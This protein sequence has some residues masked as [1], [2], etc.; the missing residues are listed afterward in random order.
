MV[1]RLLV[2]LTVVA[3]LARPTTA[4]AEGFLIIAN[5]SVNVS[6]PLSVDELAAIY[7]L[8]ITAWPDGTQI[9]PVNR[10]ATS[11]IRTDFTARVLREDSATL[12]AYWNEMHFMGKQ[13]PVVQESQ[14]SVI[15]FVRKVPGAVGY[16]SAATAPV[17]VKVLAHVP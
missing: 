10:E 9:V 11:R 6:T 17:G 15:A 14:R 12:A 5:P 13:P 8:R 4:H 16:V 3:A 2:A 7:L 1:K